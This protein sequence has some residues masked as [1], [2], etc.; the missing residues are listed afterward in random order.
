MNR[1]SLIITKNDKPNI[2]WLFS[3]LIKASSYFEELRGHEAF[4]SRLLT[5][6]K[7]NIYKDSVFTIKRVVYNPEK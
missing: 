2:E 1:R 5:Q 6:S 7:D 3:S 4:I